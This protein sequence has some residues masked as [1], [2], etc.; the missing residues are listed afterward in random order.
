MDT[1]TAGDS[2]GHTSLR[3][4]AF[5]GSATVMLALLLFLEFFLVIFVVLALC[6]LPCQTF[7]Q[8]ADAFG[9]RTHPRVS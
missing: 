7:Q 8:V 3:R 5:Y 6:R 2:P 1:E 9:A 4:I